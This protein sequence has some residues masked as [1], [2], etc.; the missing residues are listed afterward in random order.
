M[1]KRRLHAKTQELQSAFEDL[2]LKARRFSPDQLHFQTA[3]QSW[4]ILEVLEHLY[5]SDKSTVS[6]LESKGLELARAK[7]SNPTGTIRTALLAAV[8][9]SPLKFRIPS[10]RVRPTAT[11]EL[12][13]LETRWRS[14]RKRLKDFVESYPAE[15]CHSPVLPHPRAGLLTLSQTLTFVNEHFMHHLR[16]VERI[17]NSKSFPGAMQVHNAGAA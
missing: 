7:R 4:S 11:V 16:Q 6:Y 8:L 10:Q 3:P 5:L 17:R 13:E 9:R 1:T 12:D 14:I 15:H 2:F